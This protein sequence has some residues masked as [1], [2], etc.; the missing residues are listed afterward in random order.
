M[1][2]HPIS[3]AIGSE[4]VIDLLPARNDLAIR[5][6]TG[7]KAST[8]AVTGSLNLRGM[9]RYA[10]TIAAADL[11][12]VGIILLDLDHLKQAND[13]YGHGAGDAVLVETAIGAP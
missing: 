5:G 12:T 6:R 13:A 11:S 9:K 7:K 1:H 3:P 10:K 2:K 8:D 4:P